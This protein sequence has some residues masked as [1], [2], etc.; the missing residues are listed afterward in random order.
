[1]Q[2]GDVY[3]TFADVDDLVRDV[4]FKPKTGIEEGLKRFA[5]G[6]KEYYSSV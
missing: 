6:W 1:M 2:A 3:Q 5:E 4:G